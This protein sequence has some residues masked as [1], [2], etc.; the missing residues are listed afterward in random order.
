LIDERYFGVITTVL[1]KVPICA[2][3]GS[4]VG[5]VLSSFEDRRAL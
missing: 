1:L 5:G 3:C 2:V 4:T